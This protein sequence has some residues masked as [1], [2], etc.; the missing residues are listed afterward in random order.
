[1][2]KDDIGEALQCAGRIDSLLAHKSTALSN[3]R[4]LR[5]LRPI[6]SRDWLI[7]QLGT[8][9]LEEHTLRQEQIHELLRSLA[10]GPGRPRKEKPSPR[11]TGRPKRWAKAAYEVWLDALERTGRSQKYAAWLTNRAKRN[12]EKSRIL[13]ILECLNVDDGMNSAKA[14][15]EA[16]SHLKTY[17][18]RL[19]LA[20]KLSR[21][22]P[23]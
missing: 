21:K 5:Q 9:V 23:K 11:V 2:S 17:Q 8:A 15:Q 13:Y 7:V 10:R 14:Q 22:P 18:N 4:L 19:S 12:C 16:K 1:M 6:G 3:I 20:R